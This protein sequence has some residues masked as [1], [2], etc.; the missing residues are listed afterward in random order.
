MSV[1]FKKSGL[2]KINFNSSNNKKIVFKKLESTCLDSTANI[3]LNGN[4][5]LTLSDYSDGK[6]TYTNGTYLIYWYAS[7]N[8]WAC[9]QIGVTELD[10][11][12]SGAEYPWLVP[13]NAI[14]VEKQCN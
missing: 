3:I 7:N 9:D 1:I 13:W 6:P 2:N 10:G 4:I 5:L 14:T 12:E 8:R 11:I